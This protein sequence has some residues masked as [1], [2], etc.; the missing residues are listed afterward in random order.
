MTLP[1]WDDDRPVVGVDGY[2]GGW[3]VVTASAD[4]LTA[5]QSDDLAPL[6]EA[7]RAG[8]VAAAAIDMPMGLLTDRSRQSDRAARQVLGPRRSSVFPTPVRATLAASDYADACDRSRAAC[9]NALSIQA[10]NLLPAIAHLDGLIR[11]DDQ[12]RIVEAHPE[13][14]FTRLTTEP[15]GP[16]RSADGQAARVDALTA[17]LGA[18]FVELWQ[19]RA[20]HRDVPAIDLL[21]ATVLTI[22]ARRVVAGSAIF[23][24]REVD[25]RGLIAQIAY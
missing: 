18:P 19:A 23:L 3:I 20:R 12:D 1:P 5:E 2:R 13:C 21:D 11:P 15:L 7:V 24:G 14:A 16:K 8:A 9:G 22:T 10:Y 6:V 17:E 4:G 25:D